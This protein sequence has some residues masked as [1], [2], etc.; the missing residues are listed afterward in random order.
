MKIARLICAGACCALAGV[1]GGQTYD[2]VLLSQSSATILTDAAV[3]TGGV[4]IGDYDAT[5]NPE[6]TQTRPGFFGGSGNNPIDAQVDLIVE[7]GGTTSPAG[8][9]RI[10]ADFDAGAATVTGLA[11]DLLNETT[12]PADLTVSLF[13]DTFH[14][15][16]PTMIYPGGIEI[17]LPLGELGALQI[18]TMTQTEAAVGVL[19]ATDDADVFDLV[20]AVPVELMLEVV[21]TP[22]GGE[23]TTTPVGPLPAVLPLVGQVVR[24]GGTLTLTAAFGPLEDHQVLEI[25]PLELP[26]VPLELPTLGSETAGVLLTLS[27][28]TLTI[29]TLLDVTIIAEGSEAD[30]AADWT[31]DGV[32]DFFDAAGFLGDFSAGDAAADLNADGLFDFFDVQIYLGLFAAGCA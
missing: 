24:G 13:L 3:A 25:G 1:A 6:G 16:N 14:T 2:L 8:G 31:G 9:L 22:L 15:V 7:G 23:S 21:I 30:C 5:T 29:D 18:A 12:L 26:E 4:L 10:D 11:L 27:A 17:P 32:L 28:E 19:T 20:V